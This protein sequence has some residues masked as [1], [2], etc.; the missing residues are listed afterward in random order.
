VEA[1]FPLVFWTGTSPS[2]WASHA[3]RSRG[4]ADVRDCTA[5][6]A[7]SELQCTTGPH[8][9]LAVS[10]PLSLFKQPVAGSIY[11]AAPTLHT[12]AHAALCAA[13]LFLATGTR[14][15]IGM[16]TTRHGRISCEVVHCWLS[17]TTIQPSRCRQRGQRSDF[18]SAQ[19]AL[20]ASTV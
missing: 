6:I 20:P 7:N 8:R 12:Q 9:T 18:L 14:T 15:P 5:S 16:G 2:G 3:H 17:S 1:V 19:I 13:A 4:V 11:Y 10:F